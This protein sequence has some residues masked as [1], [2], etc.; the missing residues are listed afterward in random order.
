[1]PPNGMTTTSDSA[2][3]PLAA[4]ERIPPRGFDDRAHLGPLDTKKQTALPLRVLIVEDSEDDA[5]LLLHELRQ[6]GYDPAYK[7]VESAEEMEV[8]L[9]LMSWEIVIADYFMPGFN[10]LE[11]LAIVKRHGLDMP[12]IIVS[13]AIGEDTAVAA[14]KAGAHDY[15]MKGQ[16][17]RLGPAIQRELREAEVRSARR[18]AE[19]ALLTAYEE[20]EAKVAE[21][22]IELLEAN[23]K[24]VRTN[25]KLNKISREDA[26]TGLFNRRV[27]LEMANAEWARW[28]RYRAPYSVMIID[29]DDFKAVNDRYGHFIGDE[30]LKTAALT[31]TRSIRSVDMVGR[32]G[33]E[34]F[35]VILPETGIRGALASSQNVIQSLRQT[36]THHSD[37]LIKV[38]ASIG[39][40]SV[41]PEDKNVDN[42]L[43]RADAALY[44]AK[45]EGKD[46]IRISN[47][48][49]EFVQ[50][51]TVEGEDHD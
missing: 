10:A 41:K 19:K 43:H 2:V 17:A 4:S 18:Q 36:P 50:P 14:M 47:G 8:A 46:C 42:L 24:L 49:G 20:L 7:Q 34:E 13:G 27:I 5:L 29:L 1:M 48:G 26:L 33:G 23:A 38:T 28:L 6:S 3:P 30:V 45:R 44:A 21:R 51:E 22:T 40:A 32:F 39:V 12:F 31:I 16:L 25:D 9:G 11:A 35:V 15:L 37:I